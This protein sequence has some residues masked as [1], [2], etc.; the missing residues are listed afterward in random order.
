VSEREKSSPASATRSQAIE[1]LRRARQLPV[2]PARNDLRQ[3]AMGLLWLDR[4]RNET[5]YV[6]ELLSA[7]KNESEATPPGLV[8]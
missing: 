2:G 4:S 5:T 1:A 8:D 6:G 7:R 3:L